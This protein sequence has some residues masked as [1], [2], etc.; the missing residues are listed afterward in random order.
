MKLNLS[1]QIVLNKIPEEFYHPRT[2]VERSELTSFRRWK[3]V[4]RTLQTK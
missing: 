2:A 1:S 3:R 4:R